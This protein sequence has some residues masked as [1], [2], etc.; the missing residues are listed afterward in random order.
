[1]DDE[2]ISISLNQG[3]QFQEYQEKIINKSQNHKSKNKKY[4]KKLEGFKMPSP[5]I[6]DDDEDFYINK[7]IYEKKD[8]RTKNFSKITQSDIDQY[9]QI[10]IKYD[11]LL[12]KNNEL[13]TNMN[14]KGLA[15]INRTSISNPYLNK[16]IN[17]NNLNQGSL[18]KLSISDSG[19]GGYVTKMGYF[20]A[21]PD[22][23]T[24]DSVA[25][26]NGCPKDIIKNVTQNEYSSS[27]L[28]GQNMISKQS[29]GNEGQNIYV[30]KILDEDKSKY[31]GCY[32]DNNPSKT[33]TYIGD[34]PT[35]KKT[36][37]TIQNGNFSQPQLRAG[38]YDRFNSSTAVPG[39][40]FNAFLLNNSGT[41]GFP[42]PYPYGNQCV[43]IRQSQS[44]TQILYLETGFQYTLSFAAV[45]RNCCDGESNL[46]NIQLY[47]T[48][49]KLVSTIY[50][51]QP[52]INTWIIYNA[53]FTVQKSQMYQLSFRGTS[54]LDRSSAI[55]NISLNGD[56]SIGNGSYTHNMCKIEAIEN[57]YKFFALQNIN[58]ETNKGYCAVS[59]DII[60]STTYGK[61]YIIS[62]TIPLW[63][64]KTRGSGNTA[65]IT[66]RA[67]ITVYNFNGVS[68]YNTPID[69]KLFT[70]SYIGCY[71]DK[72][73]NAAMINTSRGAFLSLAQCKKLA[74]DGEYSYY[75]SQNKDARNNGLCVASNDLDNAKQ[76]GIANNCTP[77]TLGEMMGGGLSNAIHSMDGTGKYFLI[78]QD[79]GNMVVYKGTGPNDNQGTIWS[80][81]TTGKQLKPNPNY[82]AEKGKYGKN[83]I[84]SGSTL[85][86]GD[87]IGSIDGSI[88]LIMQIDGNLV[89][90]TSQNTENCQKMKDDNIG[91]GVNANALYELS[92]VGTPS[93]LGKIAYIDSDTKLKEYPSSL[94]EKS[95]DYVLI[96]N[97][98]SVGND[99][100]QI[101]SNSNANE[102]IKACNANEEC[103]G[104][105]FEPKG[106]TCYLKNSNM[107]PASK[108]QYYQDSGLVMGVRKPQLKSTVNNS[109]GR[110]IVD[111]SSIQYNN[112]IKGEQMTN[113]TICQNNI[114][115][116]EDKKNLTN[117][118]NNLITVGKD[119]TGQTNNLYSTDT[120]IGKILSTNSKNFKNNVNMY[121][122]NDTKIKKELNLPVTL[123]SNSIVE[124]MTN[125][126][127]PNKNL[128][129]NDINSMLTDT[130]IRV[131]HENY[132]YIFWS[133]L[134]VGTL[135]VTISKIQ[136]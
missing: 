91:G 112:Y 16:N 62:Q 129:I 99:I 136:K 87:F 50:N 74:K 68:I 65:S 83:W 70:G 117:L 15:S 19:Y 2:I 4:N 130:D 77:N 101:T 114:I 10:G 13:Q 115:E 31:I 43:C 133:I 38:F 109:C 120:N 22:K 78:L 7:D 47:T 32:A 102:C 40:I 113:T 45:G 25:G 69:T 21:Y 123:Q 23:A 89:L 122:S 82:K 34:D 24:F 59:K 135:T 37:V 79:D 26:K 18:S 8:I 106:K 28:Q 72:T 134:A 63:D 29:C 90:Y 54:Q 97:F 58:T 61:S 75:G 84:A 17:L 51:F 14:N 93:N 124:G 94:L 20:K 3:K 57:G 42:R 49:N 27:L 126:K 67:S 128:N 132:S 52:P 64:S 131:L 86:A 103:A 81:Q 36:T 66:D 48:D 107:Y 92:E 88:Y 96:N 44:I 105:V 95:N 108:R 60:S 73:N 39:W 127:V 30:S 80:S 85:A 71:N 104:F 41:F 119:I 35:T 100:N 5:D 56:G 98:D 118:Q 121:K 11:N 111:I 53:I 33:M 46:I 116:E 6:D 9:N 125:F 76:Y 110:D 1:M 12:N 55:Q